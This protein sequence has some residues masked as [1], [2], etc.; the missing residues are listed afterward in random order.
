MGGRGCFQMCVSL[1]G[2][3]GVCGWYEEMRKITRKLKKGKG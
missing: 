2:F 1:V 3:G